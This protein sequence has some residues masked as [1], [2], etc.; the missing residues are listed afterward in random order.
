MKEEQLSRVCIRYVC[1][2]AYVCAT[3]LITTHTSMPVSTNAMTDSWYGYSEANLSIN[4]S[5]VQSQLPNQHRNGSGR[6]QANLC[7]DCRHIPHAREVIPYVQHLVGRGG[8]SSGL[9][10]RGGEAEDATVG[11]GRSSHVGS[12]VSHVFLRNVCLLS[13]GSVV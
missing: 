9:A 1:L 12:L 5:L 11:T 7:D 6:D 8:H 2:Y 10:A 3:N 4:L 13:C